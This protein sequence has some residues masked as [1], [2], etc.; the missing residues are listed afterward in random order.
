MM[1]SVGILAIIKQYFISALNVSRLS[2]RAR[3]QYFCSGAL[4]E[5]ISRGINSS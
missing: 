3:D 5:W 2:S 4:I 1:T